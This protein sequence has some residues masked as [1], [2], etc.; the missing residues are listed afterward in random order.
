MDFPIPWTTGEQHKPRSKNTAATGERF[1]SV[2]PIRKK[3]GDLPT[4]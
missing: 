3:T 2:T 1:S 4:L